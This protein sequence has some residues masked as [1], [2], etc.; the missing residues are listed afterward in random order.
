MRGDRLK[1]M[2]KKGKEERDQKL[3]LMDKEEESKSV[4]E[5]SQDDKYSKKEFFH[6][7]DELL[8]NDS[9]LKTKGYSYKRLQMASNSNNYPNTSRRSRELRSINKNQI[10]STN[11]K[12][13]DTSETISSVKEIQVDYYKNK[14]ID[15]KSCINYSRK[16]VDNIRT[17]SY[18]KST[19]NVPKNNC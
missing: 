8:S 13:N 17:S 3:L 4:D 14:N 6:L 15:D 7:K 16:Q 12:T 9:Q 10:L 5:T 1:N 11:V 19:R 18:S 2:L